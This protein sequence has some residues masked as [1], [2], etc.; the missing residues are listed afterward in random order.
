MNRT[1]K[2][3]QSDFDSLDLDHLTREEIL[4]ALNKINDL[5]RRE[6]NTSIVVR[7]HGVQ[8]KLLKRLVQ[9]DKKLVDE[10]PFMRQTFLNNKPYYGAGSEAIQ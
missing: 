3:N 8:S 4:Q 7:I 10:F 1:G 6:Q 9:L 5:Q 2:R